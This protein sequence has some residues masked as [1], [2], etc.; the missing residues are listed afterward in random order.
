MNKRNVPTDQAAAASSE[1]DLGIILD[2]GQAIAGTPDL[3]EAFAK[4][5]QLLSQK[6]QMRRGCLLLLDDGTGRLRTER[7]YGLTPEEAEKSGYLLGEGVTGHVVATGRAKV[8]RDVREDPDF[9][10]RTGSFIA[11]AA[12]APVSFIC[13]P[14]RIEGRVC[15]AVSIGRALESDEQL[16]RDHGLVEVLAAML[17]PAVQIGRKVV[18]DKSR[19]LAELERAKDHIRD[20]FRF[21]NIIGDSPAMLEVFATV[22]QVANSR[23]TVL[24]LGETGTGKEMIAKAIHQN[25]PRRNNSF[26]RVNCGALTGTLLESEL[27][28]HVRGS[29]TGAIKDKIGRFEAADGGS[30]FL[31]EIGTLEPELQVK[32]LRVL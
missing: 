19:L 6:R 29:F 17:A 22:G 11:E 10:N 20:R 5:M 8:I 26:V 24:L 9:L 12:D 15:G 18:Y 2:L 23:A 16:R 31:D 30:I 27:F 3:R 1:H 14:I 4:I 32:L 13:V 25:S 7:S 21:D 28:G